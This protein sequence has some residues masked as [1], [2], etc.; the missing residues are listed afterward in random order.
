MAYLC[1]DC[2]NK[3]SR[4]FPGGKCPACDSFN[5]KSTQTSTRQAINDKEPKTMFQLVI[6]FLLW[7]ALAY[8]FWDRFLR[9]EPLKPAA[10]AAQTSDSIPQALRDKM[11]REP[12]AD[13]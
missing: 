2:G 9:T 13:Y 1:N 10:P 7:G 8:G 4:K 12:Q 6:M 3:S 5:I 11:Q